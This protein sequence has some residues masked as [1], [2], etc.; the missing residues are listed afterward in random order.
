MLIANRPIN[1]N[2]LTQCV[3]RTRNNF[4]TL[5][6]NSWIYYIIISCY[7]SMQINFIDEK[8]CVAYLT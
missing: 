8:F 1:T 5:N 2:L 6:I 3:L 7:Q 4:S